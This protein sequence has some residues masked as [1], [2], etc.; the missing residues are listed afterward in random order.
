MKSVKIN[1]I[2]SF[3]DNEQ[4]KS[5]SILIALMFVASIAE[6]FGLGMVILM[7]NSFLEVENSF[8]LPIL[9]FLNLNLNSINFLLLLFL[10]I[11]SI[12]Y[13]VLILVVLL[14]SNFIA[15]FR[16]KLSFKMFKN[17]LNRNSSNLLKKNSAE[18]LR[19]F[20]D[21]INNNVL[22]Y[23]SLIKII[24]DLIL[25]GVFV[26]FLIFYNPLISSSVIGFFCFVSLIYFSL[27]KNKITKWSKTALENRRKRIQFV[28]ECFSAIKFI[29]ILSTENFF[30]KKFRIENSSLSKIVFKMNFLSSI[31]R[32][33]YEYILFLSIILLVFYTNKELSNEKIIQMLSV[34]TLASFRLIPIINRVLT[35]SQHVK[36]TYPSFEKLYIEQNYPIVEKLENP[37]IFKFNKR[38]RVFIKKFEHNKRETLLKNINLNINKKDKIGIIGPSGSGKSSLVDIICGFTKIKH[39]LV[40]SD[41]KSIF[42]NLEGWQKNIGY[43]PQNIVI[44]NQSLKENIL[45]GSNPKHFSD[46]KIIS[47]LKQVNL[48][49][50]LKKLPNGLSQTIKEDG[51]NIS[52]GEKQRIGIARALLNNPQL[53]LLDEATSGLD[54]FTEYKVLETINKIKK[55]IIIVSHRINTL[56]FCDKVYNIEKNTLK[57]INKSQLI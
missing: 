42:S 12:K 11:F 55:T 52:G 14:E 6:L 40:E 7:I 32:H 24:L 49:K 35:S 9:D 15:Q 4:S 16:E 21:E 34:Y 10:L 18:Y 38:L 25:F 45:F 50:F 41:G 37:P 48:E 3:L 23:Q 39:G 43:I 17:F 28:N 46:K 53:I 1:K 22:F 31:P 19:N 26:I 20:T 27:I 30:L 5:A 8:S 2:L 13:L 29:K 47:V 51:Q 44:L 36:F 54:S 56:K 57:Q 33:T